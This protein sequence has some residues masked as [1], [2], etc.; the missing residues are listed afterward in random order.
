MSNTD[1]SV[2][3][4]L[5]IQLLTKEVC[6]IFHVICSFI[7]GFCYCI[8]NFLKHTQDKNGSKG[9]TFF[10]T[11]NLPK[12]LWASKS[13]ENSKIQIRSEGLNFKCMSIIQYNIIFFY[14]HHIFEAI[15]NS[16]NLRLSPKAG[17]LEL[18]T[19]LNKLCSRN[20][21]SWSLE[22]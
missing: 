4:E 2:N 5:F 19:F 21:L 6:H 3:K 11:K 1:C 9:P 14:P 16:L 20:V 15:L 22:I 18:D 13:F 8:Y 17:T 7:L 12:S 10:V